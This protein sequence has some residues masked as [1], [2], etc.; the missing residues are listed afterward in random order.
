MDIEAF[1]ASPVGRLTPIS[2]TDAAAGQPFNYWAY[3]PNPL[4]A[5][6]DLS[7]AALNQA[8]LAAMAVARLDQA[9]SN[10]PN[11]KLLVR[12]IIRRE[13]VSTSALEGTFAEYDEVLEA[14]FL[15]DR[16]LSAE[17]REVYNFVRAT[18]T[19]IE[20]LEKYPVSRSLLCHLQE[21]IVRGTPGYTYDAGDLRQRQ[22]YI[23]ARNRP[24]S[25]ARYVP[26]PHGDILTLG[27]SD[28]EKW[29]NAESDVPI[30]AKLAL[31]H[32]QFESLHPYADGNGRLGRLVAI[33]QLMQDGILRLPVLNLSPWLE[34]HRTEYIDG[35]LQVSTSGDFSEWVKF[36]SQAVRIQAETGVETI[37]RLVTFRDETKQ[38]LRAAGVRGIALDIA[39]N[40]IGFPALDV[41]VARTMT[42]KS[43]E[44]A[45][46]AIG[47]LVEQGILREVT[48]RRSN[49]L[50]V[51]Q[52]VISIINSPPF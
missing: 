18:E 15:E 5:V 27:F 50:F 6:P 31:A 8:T 38:T 3:V 43:F 17:Q 47:R 46:Q 16:Q 34:A 32:Y 21:I 7:L 42:G 51:C 25:E 52:K 35:L 33:L 14:D 49:R 13:A 4:P 23:G 40:L 22:V 37:S 10:L 36:F 2:G 45:N 12:P 44:A 30:I 11:P 19:A 41:T 24:I 9:L 26:P 20:M 1:R 29:V 39:E 48:G 28:W